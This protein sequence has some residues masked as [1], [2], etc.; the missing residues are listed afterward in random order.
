MKKINELEKE[1][2]RLKLANRMLD[3][4][5]TIIGITFLVMLYYIIKSS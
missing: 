2:K 1:I 5:F 3:L 4:I